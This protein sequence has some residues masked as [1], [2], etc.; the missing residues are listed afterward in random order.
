MLRDLTHWSSHSSSSFCPSGILSR[1]RTSIRRYDKADELFTSPSSSV[2][3][4]TEIATRRGTARGD[5]NGREC[6]SASDADLTASESTDCETIGSE[7]MGS[8]S[9]GSEL[10]GSELMGSESLGVGLCRG[11]S[12]A[13]Q[14]RRPLSAFF[15]LQPFR[16]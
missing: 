11:A 6:V 16:V 3:P 12:G 13:R 5:W 1:I 7:L 15:A 9:M 4:A 14:L 8:E 10:I 2:T